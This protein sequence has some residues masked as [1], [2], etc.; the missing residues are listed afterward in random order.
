MKRQVVT[1]EN[2][3]LRQKSVPVEDVT[4]P[5]RKLV[6]DM[7]ETMYASNGI[8]LAAPQI[9]E[10]IRV[11][12]IDLQ[13]R[14]AKKIALINPEILSREG[15]VESEE[16]CLSCPGINGKVSRAERVKVQGISPDGKAVTYDAD[17]LLAVCLQHE[18][19]H[20]D[21]VLFIDRM[22]PVERARA[23]EARARDVSQRAL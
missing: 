16:G 21:G 20:L 7:F 17:G 12:V 18:I 11:I 8:G 23:E 4:K 6:K 5:I 3:Q 22:N 9:G 13:K 10:N 15:T 19:D 2:P 14:G 1:E